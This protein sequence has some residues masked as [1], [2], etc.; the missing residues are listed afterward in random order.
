MNGGK[1]LFRIAVA[2]L[3]QNAVESLQCVRQLANEFHIH[4]QCCAAVDVGALCQRD[5]VCVIILAVPC[6]YV[7][8]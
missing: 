2:V 1:L 8:W 7:Q 6:L 5:I 3:V 4:L